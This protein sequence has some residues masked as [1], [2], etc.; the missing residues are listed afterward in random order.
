V[1][2]SLSRAGEPAEES[3]GRR[4]ADYFLDLR[5]DFLAVLLLE[6]RFGTFCPAAR[7]S[8]RPIAIACFRLFTFLPLRPLLSL[9]D[10]RF[11][12]AL[13]T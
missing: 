9:P 2:R 11:F 12:I 10:L 4:I 8:E 7:A 5:P 1:I 3:Q 6:T 13:R